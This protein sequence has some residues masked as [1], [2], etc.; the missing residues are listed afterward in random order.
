MQPKHEFKKLLED[1]RRYW[2]HDGTP[3]NVR[4]N[5]LKVINCGTA[6]LGAEI[7]ASS[8]ETKVV[9][10]TCKGRSCP[11]CGVW[12]T[13]LWQEGIQIS[14]PNIRFVNVNLTL[15]SVFWQYCEKYPDVFHDLSAIGAEAIEYWAYFRYGVRIMVIVIP[16]SWGGLLNFHPHFHMLVS[17][18]GLAEGKGRWIHRLRFQRKELMQAW[19]YAVIAY[20]GRI[21]DLISNEPKQFKEVLKAEYKRPYWNIFVSRTITKAKFFADA[22]RYLRRPP[23]AE[24]RLRRISETEVEY[25][26]KDTRYQSALKLRF[27]NEHFLLQL[28]R[29]V[30][31]HYR[32]GVRYFGLLAP[33]TRNRTDAMILL[34]LGQKRRSPP[35]RLGWAES[36]RRKFNMDP[37]LDSRGERM[38]Y[39]GR[40]EA[41]TVT[42]SLVRT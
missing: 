41:H 34:L 25:V 8:T 11:S 4:A 30:P 5:F 12:A 38:T 42:P 6:A 16:Q 33:R 18:G 3:P 32:H 15:P 9:F 14:L 23:I 27:S 36:L 24:Y 19:R 37:L 39:V 26:G 21:C 17:G 35:P 29:H 31:Q 10:H 1:T 2:D 13:E 28:M 20:L 40:L 22:A 7:F